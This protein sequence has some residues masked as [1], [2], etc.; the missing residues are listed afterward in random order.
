MMMLFQINAKNTKQRAST[1]LESVTEETTMTER[2]EEPK[3]PEDTMK[4]RWG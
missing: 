1:S 4:T 3:P 2:Y